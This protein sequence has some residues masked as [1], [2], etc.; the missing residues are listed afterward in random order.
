M[1]HGR[2]GPISFCHHH[3]CQTG[4]SAFHV[5]WECVSSIS[6]GVF[7][8]E[9]KKKSNC[10]G[11]TYVQC[12]PFRWTKGEHCWYPIA[13]QGVPHLR[14]FHYFPC[15]AVCINFEKPHT[16]STFYLNERKSFAQ[17]KGSMLVIETLKC[18]ISDFL[19]S[20]TC[21]CLRLCAILP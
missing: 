16:I 3:K 10:L 8:S 6:Y 7:S 20:N 17:K 18:K 4:L 14:G 1:R 12:L 19:N 9:V 15:S 21:F 2:D 11:T 13:V 5:I